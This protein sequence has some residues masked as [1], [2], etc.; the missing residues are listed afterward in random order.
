VPEVCRIE[1][2]NPDTGKEVDVKTEEGV[3][4]LMLFVRDG[5]VLAFHNRCPHQ[6]RALNF[7]PDR[8]LFTPDGQLM[9][10][11]H[12]ATFKLPGGLC[13]AGPCK[14]SSLE[15]VKTTVNGG[16]VSI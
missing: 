11:H 6:A 15:A 5:E 9:C 2:I 10:S 12:G 8:F 7:A 4:W 14:G 16:V 3:M 13:S 1:E